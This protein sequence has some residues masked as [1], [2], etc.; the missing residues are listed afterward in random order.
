MGKCGRPA[1][2]LH[3]LCARPLPFAALPFHASP[4][5]LRSAAFVL[6]ALRLLV[7]FLSLVRSW[8]CHVFLRFRT[9]A[10]ACAHS[11]YELTLRTTP[12][13]A[14]DGWVQHGAAMNAATPCY[15]WETERLTH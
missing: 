14:R 5:T 12:A 6:L 9:R 11:T 10:R 15:R 8:V 2:T 13:V 4:L 7:R 1:A 3:V